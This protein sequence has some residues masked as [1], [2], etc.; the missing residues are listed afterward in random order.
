MKYLLCTLS[1]IG[2]E[3]DII[4]VRKTRRQAQELLAYLA[5]LYPA[6]YIREVQP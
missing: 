5:P 3:L 2:E 6:L 4:A 1:P